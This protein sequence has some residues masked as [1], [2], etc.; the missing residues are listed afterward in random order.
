MFD[1]FPRSTFDIVTPEGQSRGLVEAIAAGAEI[2]IPDE[3]VIISPGDEMRRTLPNG[4]D[5]TFEV[6]DPIFNQETF[7]IPGHFLVKVRKKGMFAHKT[8]GNYHITLS[9]SNSRVNIGSIDNS[10][11]VVVDKSVLSSLREAINTHVADDGE[12]SALLAAVTEMEGA[13]DKTK[14]G[15]AYQKLIASAADHM[16]V[17]TPFL[18]ALAG[19]FGA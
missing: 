9:G 15:I 2:L 6:V 10:T 13:E 17:L 11:N 5:E 19:M 14:L 4:T 7:G 18:P 3:R 16:T 8:G 12:R 1:S